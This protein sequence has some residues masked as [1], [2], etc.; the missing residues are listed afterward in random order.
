M[1]V[2]M[3]MALG[4]SAF[5]IGN[6]YELP[7]MFDQLDPDYIEEVRNDPSI[8]PLQFARHHGRSSQQ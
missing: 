4:K 7:V 5:V 3:E 6:S 2:M 1:G 8:N